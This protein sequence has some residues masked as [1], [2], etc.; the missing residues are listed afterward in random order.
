[1]MTGC[2]PGQFI[3]AVETED[4]INLLQAQNY[5]GHPNAKRAKVDNDPRQCVWRNPTS[6]SPDYTA[7]LLIAKS[8]T[9]GIIEYQAD[10]FDRQ[11][12]GNLIA[13]KYTDGLFRIILSPD[14]L[15]VV[16]QSIPAI[17]LVGDWGLDVTQ[18]PNGNLIEVRLPTNNLY[19]HKPV[20]AATTEL[21]VV[22][23][24]PRR[25]PNAG[26]TNLNIYGVNLNSGTS[27]TVTVGGSNCPVQTI[28]SGKIIC[29]LP[30]GA[31]GNVD[32][33]V[34]SSAGSYIYQKGYRYISGF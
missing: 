12:R 26:G 24:F 23:V 7:P 11:L 17:P 6:T 19:Y 4:K 2:E 10:H 18:A 1:M 27:L 3:T 22:S 32:V 15:A 31:N 25:G 14:G 28:T 8:S 9:D 29:T 16:P 13:S 30:G 5:Y 33:A 34:S 20:E 21:R